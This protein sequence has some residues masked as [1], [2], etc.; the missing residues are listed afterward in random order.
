MEIWVP[1][2]GKDPTPESIEAVWEAWRRDSP[3]DECKVL[4][5]GPEKER[6]ADTE[7]GLLRAYQFLCVDSSFE[8]A[9]NL[10][11]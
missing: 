3:K 4:L 1:K 9:V 5:E 7:L 8:D 6:W 11:L 10:C 2:C